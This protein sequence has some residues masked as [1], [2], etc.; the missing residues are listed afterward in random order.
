M[1]SQTGQKII[2]KHILYNILRTK[3]N[4]IMKFGQLI[5][6]KMGN[7]FFEKSYAKYDGEASHWPFYKKSKLSIS[8]ACSSVSLDQQL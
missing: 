3:G 6:N 8:L 2:V 7:V 1:T 4:P 5:E